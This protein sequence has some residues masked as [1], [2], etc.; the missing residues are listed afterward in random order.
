M[1]DNIDRIKDELAEAR[2]SLQHTVSEVNRK[3]ETVGTQLK[4]V[5]L[6]ERYPLWSACIAG[7][8]GFMSGNRQ[9]GSVAVLILGGLLGAA[10]SEAWNNGLHSPDRSSSA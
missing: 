6:V 4:P 9:S 5:H 8:L 10:L 1:E 3:V 7:A 2:E